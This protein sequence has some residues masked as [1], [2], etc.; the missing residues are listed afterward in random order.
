MHVLLQGALRIYALLD[1]IS[2]DGNMGLLERQ[3]RR[4]QGSLEVMQSSVPEL[5][6]TSPAMPVNP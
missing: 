1:G 3:P 6:L 2:A 4:P 5:V